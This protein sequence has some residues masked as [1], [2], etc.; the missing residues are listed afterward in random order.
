MQFIDKAKIFIKS[1]DGGD[2]CSAFHREKYVARGGPSGG[3]GGVGGDL[4]F[5]ADP[6]KTTLIDFKFARHFRAERGENGKAELQ[7]GKDGEPMRISVPVGTI[8]RD[9]ETGTVVAD[10]S[11]PGKEKTLIKG[12]RGG[13]GN[14]RFATPTRQAPRFA[15]PGQKT[16]EREVELELKTIADVGLVGLPNVG[17]STLL[18]VLTAA[19][20]KI[21]NYHFTT[22]SPNLGVVQ[23]YEASF[24][25]ADIPGLIEG[26]AEG[27]GL[28]H[29]FLRH[30]ER[31]RMLVHV[32]DV[33]GSEGRDPI[34]DF[35]AI[36]SELSRYSEKLANL[37]Q[38]IAANKTDILPPDGDELERFTAAMEALGHRVFPI[39]AATHGG[40][41]PLLDAVLGM[42]TE[43]PPV[44]VFDEQEM[45]L[46][47]QY[48]PGFKIQ[49]EDD[50]AYAVYGGD[51]ERILDTT[52]PNDEA[53][54][55][56][57][58]QLLIKYGIIDALREHGATDGSTV[59][60]GEWE[61]DFTE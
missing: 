61:F 36:N 49:R 1:G 59:R 37:P 27:A 53:S 39:S 47:P 41:N 19:K 58:Q 40:L 56:R 16:I 13:K 9:I 15:Q 22:L 52:D 12:G 31:T 46:K 60:L 55:R 43:L 6:G 24:V 7:R 38:I 48:E 29:E 33:S 26:A 32:V 18:S 14:A 42:L 10:M 54:M 28:G 35:E 25:L 57:F 51:V 50:A 20:P 23:R 17:K 2:G 11:E 30:I 44:Q 8:V 3:D 45:T 5:V 4:V 34:E 21:A